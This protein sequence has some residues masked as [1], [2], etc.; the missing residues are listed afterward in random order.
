M[1]TLT[2][3]KELN[4]QMHPKKRVYSPVS[5]PSLFTKDKIEWN[6]TD[7]QFIITLDRN[8]NLFTGHY[9]DFNEETQDWDDAHD[10][11]MTTAQIEAAINKHHLL[12]VR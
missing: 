4:V 9:Y 2:L 8:T 10:V 11:P 3:T 6:H 1:N 5:L 7:E 12:M